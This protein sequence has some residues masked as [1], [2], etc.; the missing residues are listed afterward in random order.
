MS[1]KKE[2]DW[3]LL[4]WMPYDNDLWPHKAAIMKMLAQGVKSKN[5]LVVVQADVFE[6]EFLTRSVITNGKIDT[7]Q[8]DATNSASEDVFA[9]YLNWTE[10]QFS[11]TKWAIIFLGHGG[12]LDQ[13]SPDVHP[14]PDPNAGTQWMNIHKLNKVITE[15]NEAIQGQIELLFLQNCCKGTVEAFYNFR[16]ASNYIMASQMPLGAP[17]SYYEKVLQFL[18]KNP[19][20]DG[21]KLAEKIMEFEAN[22]MYNSYTT[23]NSAALRELPQHFTSLIDSLQTSN[24]E[25]IQLDELADK[26]WSY[27]Y[28]DDRLADIVLFFQWAVKQ[29]GANQKQL[30]NFIKF[31]GQKLIH[32]FQESPENEYPNL[33]GVSL[34][35]PSSRRQLGTYKYLEAFS[36][37]SLTEFFNS[38]LPE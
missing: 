14:V 34:C 16:D 9:D 35:I 24:I 20:V 12:N 30:Q 28:L 10:S 36:D 18:G 3:I 27:L 6:Q 15:F 13:I 32:K 23:V 33:N 26:P 4:Y 29:S 1:E 21:G 7:Q 31:F 25:N 22:K 11:G 19:G 37:L 17:N 38:I 2:Y 8:L 5:I